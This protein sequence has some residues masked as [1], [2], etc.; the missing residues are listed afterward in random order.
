MSEYLVNIQHERLSFFT[1][2]GE[3][4]ALNDVSIHLNE[5]EVLGIVGESGS[6]KSVTAYSLMGLTAYPGK[7][8]GGSLDFNGHHINDMT[9]KDFCKM[10]GNEVSII[11]QDPMTSLNPVYTIGNQI[12][13][14]IRL[15]T[16]KDKK[17]SRER[18]KELLELV[19]INEPEK[20]LKQYPHELSGGMRQRVMIAIALACEPKLL[21]ADEPTTALDVTVQAQ[22]LQLLRKIH[23]EANTSILFISH[24]LNV[25]KEVCQKVI[26][27]Y[28]GKI[29]ETGYTED[30]LYHPKHDYTKH[31]IAAI[32]RNQEDIR[33]DDLVM[34]AKDLNVFYS[35]KERGIFGKRENKHVLQ[36]VNF[37]IRRGEILGLVGE[38]G[39][40]KSTL[41]KCIVGLNKNY[42][43][44]LDIREEHP[45]LVFQDPYSSLNPMKK[46]GWILEEP[47]KVHGMKDKAKRKELVAQMLTQVGLDAS[48]ADRYPNELSGGQRQ[49]ISIGGALILNSKFIVADEPVSALDVTVQSQVLNLLL[50]LH[51]THQLTYL[52]ISHDLNIVRHFC[53]RV[54]VMYLGE[55]VEEAEVEE[56]YEDPKHPYTQL[57]FHSILTD[58]RK[59]QHITDVEQSREDAAAEGCP[60][61]HR[62]MSRS[63][64]CREKRPER[65]NLNPEGEKPHWVKCFKYQ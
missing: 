9:E 19:G 5:G 60:F 58:E 27:M 65:V 4:K 62:C 59:L 45:Q 25:I 26:V 43:G 51:R 48:Y 17:Q 55:I 7:L 32:P 64:V 53:N 24:D 12:E 40:G 8:I 52:F 15:H 21:I 18:A 36:N 47:L 56:I 2:A 35:V 30:V 1:P 11:F 3:V 46:I 6:G 38:S 41:A 57:L 37:H 16:D 10:R 28:Q 49:R 22:I 63:E 34:Q 23:M 13:E 44:E 54:I 14:V 33:E 31:L 20:R 39:C 50:D 42:T 29:V 61:Y